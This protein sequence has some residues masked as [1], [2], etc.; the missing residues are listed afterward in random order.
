MYFAVT[1]LLFEILGYVS[2]VRKG[3]YLAITEKFDKESNKAKYIKMGLVIIYTI[4]SFILP[5]TISE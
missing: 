2:F 3:K 5:L 1:F 4:T